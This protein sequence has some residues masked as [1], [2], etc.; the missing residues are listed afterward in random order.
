L[1]CLPLCGYLYMIDL[2]LLFTPRNVE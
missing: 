2:T 1:A